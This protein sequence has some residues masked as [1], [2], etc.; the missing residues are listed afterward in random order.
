[1]TAVRTLLA[2][3]KRAGGTV[4]IEAGRVRVKYPETQRNPITPVLAALR[5]HREEVIRFLAGSMAPCG[6]I[7]CAGCYQV[8][9][10]KSIHPRKMGEAWLHWLEL[11]KPKREERKQ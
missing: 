4:S 8:E 11:W 5:Q 3:F 6:D 10:G 1:M 9:P 2:D 7:A